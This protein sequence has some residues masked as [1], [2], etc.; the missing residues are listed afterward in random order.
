MNKI[1]NDNLLKKIIKNSGVIIFGNLGV[2]GLNFLSFAIF[3]KQMGP[4][5]LAILVLAQTYA[6]IFNDVFNVQTWESMVKFGAANEK[7][8]ELAKVIKTN[9]TIDIISAF[10][11]CTF[12]ILLAFPVGNIMDWNDE[13]II[14]ILSYSFSILFN[15]TTFTIGI[16]RLL[17]KFS[18]IAKIKILIALLKL[19]LIILIAIYNKGLY[20]YIMV[21]LGTDILANITLILFS[22]Y[23]LDTLDI[24]WRQE[25]LQ[26]NKQQIQFIWWTNLRTIVRIPVRHF[27]F[28]I[29]SLFM[30]IK[31]VGIYKV[32]KEIAAI[33]NKLSDPV[34]QAI[35]PVYAKLI[36]SNDIHKS[37]NIAKKTI[38]LLLCISILLTSCLLIFAKP[39]VNTFFGVEYLTHLYALYALIMLYGINFFTTPINSLFIAAG[40]AKY[41]FYLVLFT[42]TIY[43]CTAFYLVNIIGIYGIIIASATQV[44][45]NKGLKIFLMKKYSSDWSSVIR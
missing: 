3:A 35:Y 45:F 40:F 8:C 32:Y 43:L 39:L 41:G 26:L 19:F 5:A 4:E 42:N 24:K 1:I 36:G 44:I 20:Y 18:T 13:A 6:I 29:I 7:S 9:F 25:K 16:P 31:T 23:K 22:L 2:A 33:L 30:P 15:I 10:I 28:V 11:A 38:L 37:V 27:D 12:A 21:Y 34:N 14:I 17:N